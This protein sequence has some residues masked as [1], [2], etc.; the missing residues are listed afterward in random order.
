MAFSFRFSVISVISV[1]ALTLTACGGEPM[2]DEPIMCGGHEVGPEQVCLSF[3]VENDAVNM[4]GG[5]DAA[6]GYVFFGLDAEYG[7]MLNGCAYTAHSMTCN[8]LLS[9][10]DY[11]SAR[12]NVYYPGQERPY[13]YPASWLGQTANIAEA[14]RCVTQEWLDREV[15]ES[16]TA[17]G[18][19]IMRENGRSV[20]FRAIDNGHNEGGCVEYVDFRPIE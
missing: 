6:Q 1:L 4:N 8:V 15:F 17:N 12:V 7:G 18:S 10:A 2:G 14:P 20:A 11:D 9:E 19:L 3:T 13:A 5:L 16:I